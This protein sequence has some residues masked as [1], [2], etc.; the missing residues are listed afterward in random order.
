MRENS[1]RPP[2]TA[3]PVGAL[4]RGPRRC[5]RGWPL[6]PGEAA[7][8]S[9]R[10]AKDPP[11]SARPRSSARCAIVLGGH[12][13]EA[14]RHPASGAPGPA[15][16]DSVPPPSAS[17]GRKGKRPR[18]RGGDHC[19]SVWS[20]R[21][22]AGACTT[23]SVRGPSG[24]QGPRPGSQGPQAR[25]ISPPPLSGGLY[26]GTVWFSLWSSGGGSPLSSKHAVFATGLWPPPHRS[27]L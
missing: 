22:R 9:C 6:P 14:R 5:A 17:R 13:G 23:W 16:P 24:Y 3:Q 26:K 8:L 7:E 11:C 20:K 2:A 25:T 21:S 10:A 18:V 15:G 27:H 1:H 4:G 12:G 19:S